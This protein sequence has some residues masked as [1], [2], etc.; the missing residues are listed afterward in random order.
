[1]EDEEKGMSG[2]E[3]AEGESPKERVRDLGA[4][5]EEDCCCCLM[6]DEEAEA[7]GL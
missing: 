5:G 1:M 6:G 3:E 4:Q 2:E 7:D